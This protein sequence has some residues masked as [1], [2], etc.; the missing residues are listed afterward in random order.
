[1]NLCRLFVATMLLLCHLVEVNLFSTPLNICNLLNT[2]GLD[3]LYW[4]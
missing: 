3:C 2:P 1:M 4:G